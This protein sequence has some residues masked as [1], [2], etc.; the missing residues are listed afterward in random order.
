MLFAWR[1]ELINR[2]TDGLGDIPGV[3]LCVQERM[4]IEVA[5]IQQCL[6][7]ETEA[8]GSTKTRLNEVE[9][10]LDIWKSNCSK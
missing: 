4:E 8:H 3:R 2:H 9:S 6:E 10:E 5:A 7:D 1:N